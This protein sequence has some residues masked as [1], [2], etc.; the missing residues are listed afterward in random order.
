MASVC[1]RR[2]VGSGGFAVPLNVRDNGEPLYAFQVTEQQC[3]AVR[4]GRHELG[5]LYWGKLDKTSTRPEA[6][7][8]VDVAPKDCRYFTVV[9][10][11]SGVLLRET[12]SERF[13]DDARCDGPAGTG[14][15]AA[16][17]RR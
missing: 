7:A 1:I 6:T 15:P 17:V 3:F 16:T 13:R 14:P 5:A 8:T 4:P 2:A 9:M 11:L 12:D 10:G